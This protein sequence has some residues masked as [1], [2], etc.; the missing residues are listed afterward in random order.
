MPAYHISVPICKVG[1]YWLRSAPWDMVYNE[2]H[3]APAHT[4][5]KPPAHW[6]ALTQLRTWVWAHSPQP[7]ACG[8]MSTHQGRQ[9]QQMS[10][11]LHDV[12]SYPQTCKQACF[13]IQG[14][15][16]WD[17]KHEKGIRYCFLKQMYLRE[18]KRT[19]KAKTYKNHCNKSPQPGRDGK[20]ERSVHMNQTPT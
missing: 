10:P 18:S 11:E 15:K 8:H 2:L 12:C 17:K 7:S 16:K 6:A 14:T 19:A 4:S 13:N 20:L 9:T 5:L 3:L 1:L